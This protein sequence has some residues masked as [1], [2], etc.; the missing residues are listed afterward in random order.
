MKA[1]PLKTDKKTLREFGLV[2]AGGLIVFFGLLIPWIFDKPWIWQEGG[3]RWPWIG[4][5]GFAVV[6]LLLPVALKPLYL[7]WM[8]IGHALGWFNTRLILGL[9]FFVMFA[10]LAL[11]FRLFRRDPMRTGSRVTIYRVNVWRD[12]SDA[13]FDQGPV[14]F[15]QG[16]QEVLDGADHHRAA[17]AGRAH[18]AFAGLGRRTVYLY[19]VL[20]RCPARVIR[21]PGARL[22]RCIAP[23]L[24]MQG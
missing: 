20:D 3:A 15:S 18:R 4:A 7:L 6:G 5:A 9:V 16:T 12:H 21:W 2:F 22:C 1:A 10:P 11:V 8:K 14:E 24:L 17:V 19:A 13:G 23:V